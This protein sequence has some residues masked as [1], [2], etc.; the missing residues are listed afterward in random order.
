MTKAKRQVDLDA[1]KRIADFMRGRKDIPQAMLVAA[2][3]RISGSQI[4]LLRALGHI[5]QKTR[6]RN[7][8]N[9]A[10]YHESKREE[11]KAAKVAKLEAELAKL[12]A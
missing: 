6:V 4:S 1:S 9:F 3:P 12:R 5:E 11:R 2:F 7:G 10:A 8:Y